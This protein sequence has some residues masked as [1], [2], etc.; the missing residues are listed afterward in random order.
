M[1]QHGR[2]KVLN[3]IIDPAIP[4]ECQK[5]AAP[6]R[7]NIGRSSE[8]SSSTAISVG[9]YS[10]HSIT[11]HLAA[12]TSAGHNGNPVSPLS[13]ATIAQPSFQ[14]PQAVSVSATTLIKWLYRF[15]PGSADTTSIYF[16]EICI[17]SPTVS[18]GHSLLKP[19]GT[20]INKE[21]A[22]HRTTAGP[23]R[24]HSLGR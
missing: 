23:C 5:S 9:W 16:S 15:G 6:S 17:Q 18:L 2:S 12:Y 22:L 21:V 13:V 1:P 19:P 24:S 10:S 4:T 3:F 14:R 7:C 11:A 8:S 20:S